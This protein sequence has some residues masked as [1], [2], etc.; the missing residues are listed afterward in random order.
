MRHYP[1]RLWRAEQVFN[2]YVEKPAPGVTAEQAMSAEYWVHVRKQLRL[3]DTF[4]F[5][6]Q[7]G[8]Y[9]VLATIVMISPET[10][11]WRTLID[12][13]APEG[14]AEPPRID[15]GAP[16]LVKPAGRAGG[17]RV[18]ERATGQVVAEGLDKVSAE[19]ECARLNQAR[20]AA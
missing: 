9:D 10:I 13:R 5:I 8:S 19:A 18:H 12:W 20:K 14:K 17:F 1:T 4:R 7:D 6:A 2:S 11:K 15:L 3:F 16:F